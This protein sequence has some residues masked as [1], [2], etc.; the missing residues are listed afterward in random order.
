MELLSSADVQTPEDMPL[1][2]KI[3]YVDA[4]RERGNGFFREGDY[5]AAE[6]L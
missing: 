4:K 3:A 6:I 1:A 2:E 5:P